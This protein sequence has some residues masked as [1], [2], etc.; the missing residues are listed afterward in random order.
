VSV[1][2]AVQLARER[3]EVGLQ[4]AAYAGTELVVDVCSGTTAEGPDGAP[5]DHSTVFP[6]FSV[7]KAVTALAVHVQA[8]R[9]LLDCEAPVATYWPEYAAKGKAAITV[10]HVLTHQAGVPQMPVDLTAERIGDWDWIVERLAEVEPLH[11]PGSHNAYLSYSFGWILGEVVQ[12]TDPRHRSF[13]EFVQDEICEPLGVHAFWMGIPAEVEPRVAVLS[14]PEDIP[15]PR[16]GTLDYDAIP[17]GALFDPAHYNRRE[18]QRAA[19]PAAGAISDARSV[20]RIFALLANQG[21][22]DGVRLLSAERVLSFLEPRPE[23][24]GIEETYAR[25]IGMGGFHLSVDPL[26]IISPGPPDRRVLC[27]PGA[28]QSIGWADVGE[29]VALAICKNCMFFDPPEPPL[30]ALGDAMYDAALASRT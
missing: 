3:G 25:V 17:P 7:S 30:M 19:I 10:R 21:E 6:V 14:R 8:E 11:T 9:G 23:V 22:L 29:G 4:A 1:E 15:P 5:V 13:S 12:R 16:P 24:P 27:H 18:F 26:R 2:T 28:G 20:A